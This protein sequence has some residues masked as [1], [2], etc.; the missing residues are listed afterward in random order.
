MSLFTRTVCT[1]FISKKESRFGTDQCVALLALKPSLNCEVPVQPPQ[2]PFRFA[3]FKPLTR[4]NWRPSV[5]G[6]EM[7]GEGPSDWGSQD[8]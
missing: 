3:Q 7:C 2:G 5:S 8:A 1:V 4:P 6:R